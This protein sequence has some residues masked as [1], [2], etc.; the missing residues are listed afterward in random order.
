MPNGR[1]GIKYG[2]NSFNCDL[3]DVSGNIATN[4]F[5]VIPIRAAGNI[6]N[7]KR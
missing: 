5:D 7:F 3:R 1:A 4:C 6:R 2:L